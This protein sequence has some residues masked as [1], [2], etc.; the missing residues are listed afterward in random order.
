MLDVSGRKRWPDRWN[1]APRRGVPCF[2][3]CLRKIS[4]AWAGLLGLGALAAAAGPEADFSASLSPAQYAAAG[5][6]RLSRDQLAVLDGEVAR[7][8]LDAAVSP[9]GA[10]GIPFSS[11]RAPVQRSRDGLALLAPAEL[12]QLDALVAQRLA[13]PA[14][15]AAS[16]TNP[17]PGPTGG[18]TLAMPAG[19]VAPD[20]WETG[21]LPPRVH[22]SVSLTV[23][24][25]KGGS[26]YG[27][28]FSTV[29]VDP[30]HH[31]AVGFE[32]SEYHGKGLR[33]P[34]DH[35]WPGPGLV[36]PWPPGPAALP[37]P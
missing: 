14:A 4:I 10:A 20:A 32:Y 5:L 12:A 29:Y 28:D 31:F 36:G 18:G 1:P 35:G 22:G 19:S 17:G 7:D 23:G 25:G 15:L 2:T 34:S 13:A 24:G 33:C 8:G 16:A 11:R 26:F 6:P 3:V 30:A 21:P 37:A 27:G 9:T